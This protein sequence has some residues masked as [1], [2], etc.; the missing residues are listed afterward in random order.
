VDFL[1]AVRFL[2]EDAFAR[3]GFTF[4]PDRRALDKPMAMACFRDFTWLPCFPSL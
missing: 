2:A 1:D 4:T 3:A